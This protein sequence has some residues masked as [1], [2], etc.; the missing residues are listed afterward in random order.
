MFSHETLNNTLRAVS[1]SLRTPVI[2]LLL[3]AIAVS[4]IMVGTLIAELFTERMRLRVK[5]PRLVDRL[6]Q[7]DVDVKAVIQES[8]LLRRQRQSLL[9]LVEDTTLSMELRE[10]LARRLLFEEKARYDKITGVTDLIAKL[11]PML[12]LLG[13]LIPLGPGLIALGQGDTYTLSTSL[14]S[15]FDTTVAGLACAAVA[16]VVSTVRRRWYAN[17]TVAEETVMEALLDWEERQ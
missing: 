6:R 11:G 10:A 5:L 2:I 4:V 12:G 13:T 15:A 9:K 17:Y 1:A 8:G 14:L 16:H 3:L 7:T